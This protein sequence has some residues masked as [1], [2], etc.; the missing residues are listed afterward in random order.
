[1]SLTDEDGI[2]GPFEKGMDK[3]PGKRRRP[4]IERHR[5]WLRVQIREALD[6]AEKDGSNKPQVY[7]LAWLR[8]VARL[9][10]D[11][12]LEIVARISALST[13]TGS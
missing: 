11:E 9:S 10:T 5:S 1:M 3:L 2:D 8:S 4:Q 13:R 7:M 6:A 12:N